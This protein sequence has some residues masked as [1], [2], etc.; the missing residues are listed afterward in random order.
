[1]S[2]ETPSGLRRIDLSRIVNELLKNA[3]PIPLEFFADGAFIQGTIDEYLTSS[4]LSSETTL[5]LDYQPA[6]LPPTYAASFEHEDWVSSLDVLSGSSLAG[7]NK[8]E[9]GNERIISGC[10]NGAFQIW[11]MSSDILA[12]SSLDIDDPQIVNGIRAV[13]FISPSRVVSSTFQGQVTVWDYIDHDASLKPY[14]HLDGHSKS[15]ASLSIN[16]S[17]QRILTGSCDHTIG[18]WSPKKSENP[19]APSSAQSQTLSNKSNKKLRKASTGP[20]CG[21]LSILKGHSAAV[22]ASMFSS[23]DDTVA[24]SASEDHKVITWDLTSSKA[25]D[26]R[27]TSS[28][29]FTLTT[30]P[31]LNLLAVGASPNHITLVDPRATATSVTAMTLKGHRNRVV[32]LASDPTSDHGLLSGSHDSTCKVWDLRSLRREI[33]GTTTSSPT[34][35]ILRKSQI[36]KSRPEQGGESSVYAVAWDRDVGIISGGQDGSVDIHRSHQLVTANGG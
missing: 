21:A 15:V 27:V 25:V 12:T 2:D 22:S 29:L 33:D 5:R 23:T 34:F 28:A 16:S 14:V 7:Q 36:G 17:C 10:N 32:S 11:N 9:P 20:I 19:A 4:G 8:V 26:T 35:T 6:S 3:R 31:S 13:K 1:M 18:L 24:Y 30:L